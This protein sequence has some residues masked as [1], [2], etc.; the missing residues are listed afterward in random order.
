MQTHSQGRIR[1][2]LNMA[3]KRVIQNFNFNLNNHPFNQSITWVLIHFNR[4]K[5]CFI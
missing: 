4:I 1:T 5:L 2:F 3:I